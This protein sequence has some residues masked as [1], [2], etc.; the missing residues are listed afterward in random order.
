MRLFVALSLPEDVQQ[1]LSGL[2]NGLP[3]ARWVQV[4]EPAP[5]PAFPG[6][7]RQPRGGGRGRRPSEDPQ[8]RLRPRPQ[9]HRPFRRGAQAARPLG[10][11]RRQ[12]RTDAPAGEDRAGPDSPRA[13]AG[14]A[15]VQAAHHPWPA[16]RATRGRACRPIWRITTWCAPAR[17][18]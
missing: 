16:S 10:R 8:P 18:P 14:A 2:A 7:G 1:R 5:D 4:R 12:R 3:G 11:G 15:Q 6:R 17:S 13:A 9:R